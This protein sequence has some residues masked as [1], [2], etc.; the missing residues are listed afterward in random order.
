MEFLNLTKDF[1]KLSHKRKFLIVNLTLLTIFTNIF[2]IYKI[3]NFNNSYSLEVKI[4]IILYSIFVISSLGYLSIFDIYYFAIPDKLT[5][6]LPIIMAIISLLLIPILGIQGEL[7]FWQGNSIVPIHSILGGIAG[8]I[9]IA[10]IVFVTQGNGMGDGDIRIM[11]MVGLLVGINRLLIAF[12]IT[13]FTGLIIGL[14]YTF[15]IKKF[16]DVPIPFVPFIAIGGILTFVLGLDN[17]L[18]LNLFRIPI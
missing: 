2:V 9:T 13:I 6:I 10:L 1:K 18:I 3:L 8:A 15:I 11:A 12:Y 14:V 4:L 7:I 17:N 5:L 16:K